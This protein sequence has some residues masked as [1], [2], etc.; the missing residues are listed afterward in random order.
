MEL[1]TLIQVVAGSCLVVFSV[2]KLLREKLPGGKYLST[3][4]Y[5]ALYLPVLGE[6]QSL[7][8]SIIGVLTFFICLTEGDKEVLENEETKIPILIYESLR[9]LVLTCNVIMGLYVVWKGVVCWL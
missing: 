3:L 2:L 1:Q 4:L 7:P 9:T 5:T 6:W 8:A